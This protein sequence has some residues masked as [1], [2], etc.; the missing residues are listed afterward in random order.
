MSIF[1]NTILLLS[2]A[3]LVSCTGVSKRNIASQQRI[4]P[5]SERESL[6]DGCLKRQNQSKVFLH[7]GRFQISAPDSTCLE[8]KESDDGLLI[9]E[10]PAFLTAITIRKGCEING[11]YWVFGSGQT[12]LPVTVKDLSTGTEKIYRDDSHLYINDTESFPCVINN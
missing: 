7:N 6:Y 8:K 9:Y 11:N 10:E 3:T 4:H 1:S 12:V 5:F 2:V